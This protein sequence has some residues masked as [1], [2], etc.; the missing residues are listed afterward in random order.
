MYGASRNQSSTASIVNISENKL[1]L[2]FYIM[3]FFLAL[4]VLVAWFS[5]VFSKSYLNYFAEVRGTEADLTGGATG[6]D[7]I[8]AF[9]AFPFSIFCLIL[10]LV[11]DR[12]KHISITAGFFLLLYSYVYQVNY[13]I[14]Y[15]FH[16]ILMTS[17]LRGLSKSFIS[18]LVVCLLLVLMAASM[19]YGSFDFI[20]VL[21]YYLVNYHIVGFSLYDYYFYDEQG[22]IHQHTFGFSSLGGISQSLLIVIDKLGVDGE[23]LSTTNSYISKPVVVGVDG[24]TKSNAFNTMIFTFFR[25]FSYFGIFLGGGAYGFFTFRAY[26]KSITSIYSR[27]VFVVLSFSWMI[28]FMISP[29]ERPYF[30]FCLIFSFI[31]LKKFIFKRVFYN[32]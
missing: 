8:L 26:F 13:P 7:K 25:D 11:V 31:F 18:V 9:L 15:S 29:I 30:W 2:I 27:V 5:G 12:V 21:N 4:T 32:E 19:R 23:L 20:G 3:L 6:L 17:F 10:G 22:L 28:G 1:K 16:I 14:M 24:V